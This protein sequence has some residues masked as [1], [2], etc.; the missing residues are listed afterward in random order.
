MFSTVQTTSRHWHKTTTRRGTT[1]SLKWA[2]TDSNTCSYNE[3]THTNC[4]CSSLHWKTSQQSLEVDP[5][6]APGSYCLTFASEKH[7]VQYKSEKVLWMGVMD[8]ETPKRHLIFHAQRCLGT[9]FGSGITCMQAISGFYILVCTVVLKR[10]S[11]LHEYNKDRA[12]GG[13]VKNSGLQ[14]W[15]LVTDCKWQWNSIH[16]QSS[17]CSVEENGIK[18]VISAPLRAA[19]NGLV[20]RFIQTCK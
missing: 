4:S 14:G 16:V 17:N 6:F 10:A 20:K 3:W 7:L 8:K 18:H 19:T 1:R 13:C 9:S 5:L 12:D 15:E 2:H 11:M